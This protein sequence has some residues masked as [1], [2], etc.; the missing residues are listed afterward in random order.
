MSFPVTRHRG[1]IDADGTATVYAAMPSALQLFA[2]G[3]LPRVGADPV[4]V[5]IGGRKL[6]P[7]VLAAVRCDGQYSEYNVAVLVFKPASIAA[8][9]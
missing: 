5:V 9:P 1:V 8:T 7:M 4:D 3:R 2:E 6:G